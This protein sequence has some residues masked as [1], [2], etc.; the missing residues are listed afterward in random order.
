LDD[1]GNQDRQK[2]H[3]TGETKGHPEQKLVLEQIDPYPAYHVI[4]LISFH[5]DS[6]NF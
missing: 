3:G 4:A 1:G 5:D 2:R 6:G